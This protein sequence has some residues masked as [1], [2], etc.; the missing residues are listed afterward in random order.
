MKV[1]AVLGILIALLMVV[2]AGYALEI[3]EGKEAI[4][5][6]HSV[7]VLEERRPGSA[8]VI[9]A[10]K[11]KRYKVT[12]IGDNWVK[13]QVADGQEGWVLKR[14]PS[15]TTEAYV[16]IVDAGATNYFWVIP[17]I[18]LIMG[19]AAFI[20]YQLSKARRQKLAEKAV[21]V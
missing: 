14:N 6:L 12:Q 21:E 18:I 13:L 9:M 20:V 17:L 15:D 4:I 16:T 2:P 8:M 5:N 19:G 10:T 7:P 11:G 1:T 3:V